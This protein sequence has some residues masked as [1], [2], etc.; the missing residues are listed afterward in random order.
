MI[1]N[2]PTDIA[3]SIEVFDR[4]QVSLAC[5]HC[6]VSME[7]VE[8]LLI[9]GVFDHQESKLD[10]WQ[11]T[12]NQYGVLRR[13]ARLHRDLGINPPGIALALDLLAQLE[14]NRG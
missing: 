5:Q 4:V 7:F 3:V 9:E 8:A 1:E 13:A 6:K 11:L 2:P 10:D 12:Q 14:R